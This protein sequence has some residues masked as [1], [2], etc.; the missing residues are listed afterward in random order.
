[1]QFDVVIV[2]GGVMGSAIA[3][4]LC[5]DPD[6]HGSVAIIERDPSFQRASSSLSA[7]AIRTQ[8]T[9]QVSV[10]MS[11]FG[12]EFLSHAA[13]YLD[14]PVGLVSRG[15]LLLG[16]HWRSSETVELLDQAALVRRFPWLKSSDLS[17]ATWG[18]SGEGWFDGPALHAALLAGAR[19]R[20]VTLIPAQAQQFAVRNRHIEY[21]QLR[22]GRS[23]RGNLFINACGAWAAGLLKDLG[24][25]LPVTPRKRDVFVFSAPQAPAGLP[26]V[27]DPSGLWFRP[28]GM[29]FL[30]GMSPALDPDDAELIPDYPRF[31]AEL[32]PLLASR[33][34]AFE[35]LRLTGAWSGYY[36]YCRFD[37]NGF[38]GPVADLDNLLFACGF[39]GHGMQHA[40]AVGRGLSELIIHGDYRSLDLSP[41]HHSRIA[42][43]APLLERQVA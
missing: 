6:F 18:S 39:S 4:F 19:S 22:D 3:W 37:Q 25:S 20:G 9:T 17:A 26:M 11:E 40:P 33:V 32:W 41:L 30:C 1:M 31:E 12:W 7:S 10:A 24:L 34:P 23:V 8:F 2:G 5:R 35:A 38:V 15:Y 14:R 13:E 28:E 16:N 21:L 42:A 27:W 36:E 43:N 29:S